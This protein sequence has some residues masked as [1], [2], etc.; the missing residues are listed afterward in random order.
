MKSLALLLA[1]FVTTFRIEPGSA[2]AVLCAETI[3]AL[4]GFYGDGPVP[5]FEIPFIEELFLNRFLAA[6]FEAHLGECGLFVKKG[7]DPHGAVHP[8]VNAAIRARGR[9]AKIMRDLAKRHLAAVRGTG[10]PPVEHAVE[11]ARSQ[12]LR[13]AV[14]APAAPPQEHG[15][16]AHAT[17]RGTGVPPVEHAVESARSQTPPGAVAA[18]ATPSEEHGQ[19]GHATSPCPS[20]PVHPAPNGHAVAPSLDL[21]PAEAPTRAPIFMN[22]AMRRL[23]ER[24][25]ARSR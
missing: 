1:R 20:E 13:S 15:Q 19:D 8:A 23:A 9:Y 12:A 16:D 22:R 21:E 11:S 17:V 25:G 4:A 5:A 3:D 18:P 10:V 7:D 6:R 14:A 2:D 24:N